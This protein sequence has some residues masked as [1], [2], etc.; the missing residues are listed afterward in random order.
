MATIPKCCLT[1]IQV[2]HFVLHA[3]EKQW[4]QRLCFG[5]LISWVYFKRSLLSSVNKRQMKTWQVLRL[6]G[7]F[8]GWKREK[9]VE[10]TRTQGS[11]ICS[12]KSC[13]PRAPQ[14]DE[15]HESSTK[16]TIYMAHLLS[17]HIK[18]SCTFIAALT[19]MIAPHMF[20]LWV[21]S[22]KTRS[23]S[24]SQVFVLSKC[25]ASSPDLV[26]CSLDFNLNRKS[27]I[28]KKNH[29]RRPLLLG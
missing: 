21:I 1:W 7:E 23:A 3:T 22:D 10:G 16:S 13:G 4:R 5:S 19:N 17:R 9:Q 12:D 6:S 20:T 24:G 15:H 11:L 14:A 29:R 8:V 18:N 25:L 28:W 27:R 26:I 2:H